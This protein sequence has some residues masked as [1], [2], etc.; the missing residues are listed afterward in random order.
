[1]G[2]ADGSAWYDIRKRIYLPKDESS[3]TPEIIADA[4]ASLASCTFDDYEPDPVRCALGMLDVK[5][6][7]FAEFCDARGYERP[8][9]WF[10]AKE[11]KKGAK[12]PSFPGRPSVMGSIVAEFHRRVTA[13]E[14]ASKVRDEARALRQWAEKHIKQDQLP[15][16][17]AIENTIRDEHRRFRSNKPNHK[18]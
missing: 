6:K 7:A 5:R 13:G 3:W 11:R 14:V 9:F 18:I 12:L 10:S 2:F 15:G 1:M 4:C 17:L 16:M 8:D